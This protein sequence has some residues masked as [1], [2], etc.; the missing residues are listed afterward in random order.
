MNNNSRMNVFDSARAFIA[1]VLSV[2][3][4]PYRPYGRYR[5]YRTGFVVSYGQ[6]CA[7]LLVADVRVVVVVQ[8]QFAIAF[9]SSYVLVIIL[10][11]ILKCS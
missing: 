2:R 9:I 10:K 1:T 11:F 7:S 5:D 6:R 3:F 8:M 4:Q